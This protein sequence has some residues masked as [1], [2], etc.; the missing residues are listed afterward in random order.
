MD[1]EEGRNGLK[2]MKGGEGKGREESEIRKCY[3]DR[4]LPIGNGTS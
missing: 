4:V 3:Y 2:R 1:L